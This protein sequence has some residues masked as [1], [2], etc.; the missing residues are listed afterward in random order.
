MSDDNINLAIVAYCVASMFAPS[1]A[2]GVAPYD[3]DQNLRGVSR[4]VAGNIIPVDILK[5]LLLNRILRDHA[6]RELLWSDSCKAEVRAVVDSNEKLLAV[7]RTRCTDVVEVCEPQPVSTAAHVAGNALQCTVVGIRRKHPLLSLAAVTRIAHARAAVALAVEAS[8][9]TDRVRLP[10]PAALAALPE[11]PTPDALAQFISLWGW[12]GELGAALG[13]DLDGYRLW[14]ATPHGLVLMPRLAAV[15]QYLLGLARRAPDLLRC[16]GDGTSIVSLLTCSSGGD[17]NGVTSVAL[18]HAAIVCILTLAMCCAWPPQGEVNCALDVLAALAESDEVVGAAAAIPV[19]AAAAAGAG[20]VGA[21]GGANAAAQ[22]SL[23]TPWHAF[24]TINW[25]RLLASEPPAATWD[26]VADRVASVGPRII[27]PHRAAKLSALVAFLVACGEAGT[28]AA[29]VPRSPCLLRTDLTVVFERTR[30]SH[31]D[32]EASNA[33]LGDVASLRQ[34]ASD[35]GA[36]LRAAVDLW[37]RHAGARSTSSSADAP[38]VLVLAA[39]DI[40]ALPPVVSS[41]ALLHL[42]ANSKVSASHCANVL[43]S[44]CKRKCSTR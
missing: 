11:A 29:H 20:D 7:L 15:W 16:V 32:L 33:V 2:G 5:P 43:R 10:A 37:S 36:P 31:V 14:T 40:P 42:F 28:L 3:F 12:P 41:S 8:P 27:P 34:E 1:A 17:G 26:S 21:E 22:R 6:L 9:S 4:A 13:A 18:P 35:P 24:P 30:A 25:T 23:P 39:G 44:T 38:T 19:S